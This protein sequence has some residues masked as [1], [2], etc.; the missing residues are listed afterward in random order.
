[1]FKS[2][3]L[4]CF[5]LEV[6]T[7]RY[8]EALSTWKNLKKVADSQTTLAVTPVIAQLDKLK[9]DDSEVEVAGV[10]SE[11]TWSLHLFKPHFRAVV[12]DGYLSQVKLR[13]DK[14]YV[15]FAFDPNLNYE[16]AKR[17]G[18]CTIQLVGAPGTHFI[19]VQF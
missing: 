12:S 10:L 2:A 6:N 18:A 14:R 19:L 13:C 3:L 4:A 16:V 8:A 17:Y 9:S 7:H 1:M 15:Y 11:T 5:K